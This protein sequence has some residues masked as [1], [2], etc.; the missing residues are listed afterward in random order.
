MTETC[1]SI[2]EFDIRKDGDTVTIIQGEKPIKTLRA[3]K[4]K[5][6]SL[7]L[8]LKGRNCEVFLTCKEIPAPKQ[9]VQEVVN[10]VQNI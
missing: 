5:I 7:C 4:N 6:E 3:T 2:V 10:I 8:G 9:P 1:P